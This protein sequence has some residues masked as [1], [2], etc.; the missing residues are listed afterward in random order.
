MGALVIASLFRFTLWL[1]FYSTEAPVGKELLQAFFAGFR[2]D[3]L[4]FGFF[5]LGFLVLIWGLAATKR[6]GFVPTLSR[7]Y[8]MA[9][10]TLMLMYSLSEI[11]FVAAT[12]HRINAQFSKM[13]PA[14]IFPVAFAK[15]N[16]FLLLLISLAQVLL[17]I[18]LYRK[19]L[20]LPELKTEDQF[21][22]SRWQRACWVL[23]SFLMAGLAA[24]GTLTAHHLRYEDSLVSE[25]SQINQIPLNPL[26]S[27]DKP[28]VFEVN[29]D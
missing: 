10:Q 21:A 27:Q 16:A 12:G 24:R 9:I 25:N 23:C 18:W 11:Y 14:E 5:W 13:Q 17:A 26:W 19:L 2:F 8:W 4:I 28:I 6:S 3:L 29:R 1:G 7:L 20:R 15:Q 22:G